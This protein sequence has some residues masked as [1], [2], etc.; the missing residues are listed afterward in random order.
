M[1]IWQVNSGQL[2]PYCIGYMFIMLF[3]IDS[4][5]FFFFFN[6][7]SNVIILYLIGWKLNYIDL[8][9]WKKKFSKLSWSLSFS[10][11]YYYCLF[12][13]YYLVKI[14]LS[15][16]ISKHFNSNHILKKKTCWRH[17]KINFYKINK[18]HS[19]RN[20]AQSNA[21]YILKGGNDE[22]RRER[23]QC[24]PGNMPWLRGDIWSFMCV[25]RDCENGNL[26]PARE[27]SWQTRKVKGK[28]K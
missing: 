10:S 25:G 24:W 18:I 4:S 20:T 1:Q 14:K 12:C 5:C 7:S 22:K 8:W 17:L 6:F 3:Q 16:L 23:R 2:D 13:F 27:T 28:K 11:I 9:S 15:Y 19:R 26:W 21:K